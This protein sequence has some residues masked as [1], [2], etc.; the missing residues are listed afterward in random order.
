MLLLDKMLSLELREYKKIKFIGE[1]LFAVILI[2][3][4]NPSN[5]EQI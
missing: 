2:I 1:I 3:A 5:L 4:N